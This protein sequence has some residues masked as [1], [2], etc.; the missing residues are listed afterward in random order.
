MRNEKSLDSGVIA[1]FV[2]GLQD[3]PGWVALSRKKQDALLEHTSHIQ[4]NRQLQFLGMF[5]EML[6][7]N[8]VQ[9]LLEGEEMKMAD[10][11]RRLYPDKHAKTIERKERAFSQI[12]ANIP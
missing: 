10:Y 8:K 4:Q 3:T 2:E 12:V 7:L 11:L 9:Q 6:E 5:G 1:V